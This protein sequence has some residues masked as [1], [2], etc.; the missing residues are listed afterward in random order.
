MVRSLAEP[1]A[2]IGVTLAQAGDRNDEAFRDFAYKVAEFAPTRVFVRDL[3]EKYLRGR[4]LEEMFGLFFKAFTERNV[5]SSAVQRV[6]GEVGA[7]EAALEWA[8]PGD[9][10][11]HLVHLEREVVL[12]WLT[13]RQTH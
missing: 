11:V 9:W 5:P 1:G 8:R 7:L 13:S 6:V 3:P 10:V 4:T 2:R 12:D